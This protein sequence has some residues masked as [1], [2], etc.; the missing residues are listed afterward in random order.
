MAKTEQCGDCKFH[1]KRGVCPKAEYKSSEQNRIACL[2][3][4]PA[5]ELFQS[6]KKK[7]KETVKHTPGFA[8][9]GN[10][11]EQ[12]KD[13]KYAYGK[14]LET[15]SIFRHEGIVYQ[16]L[17]RCPWP[18]PTTPIAYSS[19]N[20]LWKDIR[21]F[22]NDHLFLPSKELYDVLTAWVLA[23][24]LQELWTVVPY[25]FFYGPIASG[26]TRGLETLRS[27]SFRGIL[28]SNISPAALFRA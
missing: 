23:T 14:N 24:W 4:D 19:A 11:F 28:A 17:E 5:C 22:I 20:E 18:L 21:S 9:D 6:K 12:I 7:Q 26:K 3:T 1:L 8:K 10:I 16:P 2:S 13:E 25:I 27:I 15:D